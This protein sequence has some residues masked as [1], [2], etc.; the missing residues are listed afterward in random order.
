MNA[1]YGSLALEERPRT[2]SPHMDFPD[3][4]IHES[5]LVVEGLT[6][7]LSYPILIHLGKVWDYST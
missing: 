5:L 1:H 3:L 6:N 4:S 2:A 7:L